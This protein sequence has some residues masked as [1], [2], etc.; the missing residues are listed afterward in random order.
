MVIE[1]KGRGGVRRSE[2]PQEVTALGH[3]TR[4]LIVLCLS[5]RFPIPDVWSTW[6]SSQLPLKYSRSIISHALRTAGN[7]SGRLHNPTLSSVSAQR[8]SQQRPR[9]SP[10]CPNCAYPRTAGARARPT[11]LWNRPLQTWGSNASWL[12]EQASK[13][14]R[15]SRSSEG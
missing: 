7:T 5:W 2:M 15:G 14:S 10:H 4:P 9:S 1:G 8:L 13:G 12:G 11:L 6:I 3:A